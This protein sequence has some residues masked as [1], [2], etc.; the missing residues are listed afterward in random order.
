MQ[1]TF[2]ENHKTP[3][4]RPCISVF[5]NA[6][7]QIINPNIIDQVVLVNNV[8]GQSIKVQ[9]C[10]AKSSDCIIVPLQ[11]YQKLERVLGVAAGST[12]FRYEYRELF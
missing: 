4:G 3:D 8:C 9:V 11:G 1:G 10:Y 12:V 5:A 6:R 7:R 2:T